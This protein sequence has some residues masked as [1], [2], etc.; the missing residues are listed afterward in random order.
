MLRILKIG[1]IIIIPNTVKM[2]NVSLKLGHELQPPI[3]SRDTDRSG[4]YICG[5][6]ITVLLIKNRNIRRCISFVL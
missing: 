1:I 4:I 2:S 6:H 5:I 3:M